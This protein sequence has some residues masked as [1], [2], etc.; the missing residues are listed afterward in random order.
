[1]KAWRIMD[2]QWFDALPAT[3]AVSNK[4]STFRHGSD[5][6]WMSQQMAQRVPS[7]IGN[8]VWWAWHTFNWVHGNPVDNGLILDPDQVCLE[9]DLQDDDALLCDY[10]LH[11]RVL[12]NLDV[13]DS[14][15]CPKY[16]AFTR[17]EQDDFIRK[18]GSL[19]GDTPEAA[20]LVTATWDR[21][22][23]QSLWKCF[24]V[25]WLGEPPGKCIQAAF[26]FLSR[27]MVVDVREP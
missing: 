13:F 3:G 25:A 15:P 4:G 18:Y 22:F 9:L 21:V 14:R 16:V 7:Y 6:A 8:P 19:C 24:D 23:D 17:Q 10:M 26:E 12:I 27:D 11:G 5:R 2:R 20:A 1:M